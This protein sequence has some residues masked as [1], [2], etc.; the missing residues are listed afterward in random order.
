MIMPV[1]Y[2]PSF[3]NLVD[4]H[5]SCCMESEIPKGHEFLLI[6]LKISYKMKF[7]MFGIFRLYSD[8][9]L[10]IVYVLTAHRCLM[11]LFVL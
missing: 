1:S 3:Y 9:I 11:S 7:G 4:Y 10:K 2:V 6:A 5:T 8:Y